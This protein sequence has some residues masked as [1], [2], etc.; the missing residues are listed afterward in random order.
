M[1]EIHIT[2]YRLKLSR[3]LRRGEVPQLR[4]FFGRR[5]AEQVLLHHHREDGSLLYD[6]PRIQFKVLDRQAVLIGLEE[7]SELLTQLWLEVDQAKLGSENLPV[8]EATIQKRRATFGATEGM[9]TYRFLSPWLALNQ[10]NARRY[11][12]SDNSVERF[13]LLESI[14]VGNCLSFAKSFGYTVNMRLR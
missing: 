4:G 1:P 6:Y 3:E 12:D 2:E 7:G 14:I 11:C 10:K 5:F 9:V 13:R 8:Q